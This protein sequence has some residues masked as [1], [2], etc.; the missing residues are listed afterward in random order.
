MG[1]HTDDA[2]WKQIGRIK[3]VWAEIADQHDFDADDWVCLADALDALGYK[4]AKKKKKDPTT[5]GL[6]GI[7]E[8]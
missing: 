3:Q 7:I 1:F 5:N 6:F 2:S 8:E 4:I